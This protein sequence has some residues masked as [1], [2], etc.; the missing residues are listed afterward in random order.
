MEFLKRYLSIILIFVV[1]TISF[2]GC[3]Q[4]KEDVDVIKEN[5]RYLMYDIGNLPDSFIRTDIDS[6]R[7]KDLER[8]LFQGLVYEQEDSKGN[9][10]VGYALAKN[11][12][13]SKDG[14]VYTFTLKD[15]IKW[16]DGTNITANDFVEFFK[17]VLSQNYDSVYRYELK[18]IYGAT[19]FIKNTSDFSKVAITAPKDNVLEIRLNYPSPHFLQML[20]QPMYGLRRMDSN[21]SNWKSNYKYIKYS[22]AFFINQIKSNGYIV[23]SKNS[24]Y[25]SKDSVKSSEIILTTNK[26]GSAY[27]LADFETYNNLDIFLNPPAAEVERLKSEKEASIFPKL[28]V[29]GLF[30]NLKS[31]NAVSNYNFRKAIELA[32]NRN[33]LKNNV[34]GDYGEMITSYLPKGINSTNINDVNFNSV[35]QENDVLKYIENSSYDKTQVIKFIYIDN[36]TNKKVC[37]DIVKMIND[38]ISK[39]NVSGNE[40]KFSNIK[41]QLEGYSS[42]KINDV[43]KSNNY[44]MYLGDYNMNY[45]D[46][47]SFLEIWKSNSPYNLYGFKDIAYDDFMYTGDVTK[48]LNKKYEIYNKCIAELTNKMPV[49]P[50]YSKNTIACSKKSVQGLSLNKFGN[51]LIENIKEIH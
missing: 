16:N 31:N 23:L 33:E 29:K 34:V 44:D 35:P 43:L 5:S 8:V 24:Y 11:C 27:S 18:C 42:E 46:I 7:V 20:T 14:L 45:N 36:D 50:L 13:I 1:I 12:D 19:D 47:M 21:I 38:I 37:E 10:T 3:V 9:S 28:S 15:N 32:L 26:N 41:F 48:D 51:V 25:I 22:G 30:F 39:N 4:K 2:S 49:I 40:Q 17:G 6:S